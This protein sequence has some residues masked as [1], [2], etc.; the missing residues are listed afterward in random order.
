MVQ[1]LLI[2]VLRRIWEY[3]LID[4]LHTSRLENR[5]RKNYLHG[6]IRNRNWLE[7]IWGSNGNVNTV[8]QSGMKKL[9]YTK[10]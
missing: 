10:G 6:T 5:E 3:S 7:Q 1:I 2:T 4:R 8:P 9:T